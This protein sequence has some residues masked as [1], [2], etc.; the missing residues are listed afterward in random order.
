MVGRLVEDQSVDASGGQHPEHARVRSPGESDAPARWTSSAPR[1]NFASASAG[2]AARE[3]ALAA[4]RR[5]G[6]R[7]ANGPGLCGNS[8]KTPGP[9]QRRPASS[10]SSPSSDPSRVVL[11]APLPPTHR[12]PVAV[13]DLEVDGA[14]AEAPR[15]TTRTLEPRDDVAARAA[16]EVQL[17]PPGRPRL[18]HLLQAS[19][20]LLESLAASF[21]FFFLRPWP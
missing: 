9:T 13:R 6:V 18:L 20:L 17:E 4:E 2:L 3:S 1:P 15:P 7:P 21:V 19:E 5:A 10:G 11:P 12:D 14:K 16:C 8:P